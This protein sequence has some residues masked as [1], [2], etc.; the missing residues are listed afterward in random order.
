MEANCHD[1]SA[2]KARYCRAFMHI[3]MQTTTQTH[4]HPHYLDTALA[5]GLDFE[6]GLGDRSR[7]APYAGQ[8][9]VA[10]LQPPQ[11]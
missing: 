1:T 7:V 3:M 8:A 2:K 11:H 10:T 6:G 9:K 5:T 4:A